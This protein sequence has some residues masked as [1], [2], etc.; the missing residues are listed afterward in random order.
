MLSTRLFFQIIIMKLKF[1]RYIF[2]NYSYIKF[3]GN[4]DSGSSVVPYRRTDTTDGET[5]T[6]SRSDGRTERQIDM[7]KLLVAFSNYV[8]SPKN[9]KWNSIITFQ[10]RV[11]YIT[12]ALVWY[13]L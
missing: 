12:L 3:R 6:D 1:F 7:A 9:S 5:H 8:N 10:T 13:S 2:K 4:P 11:Q